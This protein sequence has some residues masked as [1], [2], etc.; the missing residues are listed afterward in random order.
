MSK[1][2]SVRITGGQIRVC[3]V[4]VELC[5]E[6]VIR[7][8]EDEWGHI[9]RCRERESIHGHEVG[10]LEELLTPEKV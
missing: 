3:G 1:K 6:A 2:T 5:S 4:L 10:S 8:T 9:R 7:L